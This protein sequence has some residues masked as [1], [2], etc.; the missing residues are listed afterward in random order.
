MDRES[1]FLARFV[2]QQN[3]GQVKMR[4]KQYCYFSVVM[5][6]SGIRSSMD[7]R[8]HWNHQLSYF[9]SQVEDMNIGMEIEIE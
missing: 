6:S 2:I 3:K 1:R 7:V 5:L 8:I 9:S 4:D